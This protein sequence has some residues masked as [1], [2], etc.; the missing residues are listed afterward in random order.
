ML[1]LGRKTNESLV[2]GDDIV[3]TILAVDRGFCKD[4][5][6]GTQ[7]NS[8]SARR[9]FSSSAGTRGKFSGHLNKE[10]QEIKPFEDLRA[11]LIEQGAESEEETG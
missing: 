1:V 7:R 3:I 6:F 2:I 8:N 11:L 4:W 5:C 9:T 10:T